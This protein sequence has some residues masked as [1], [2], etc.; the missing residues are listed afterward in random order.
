MPK[1]AK[2]NVDRYKIRGGDLNEF[3]FHQNQAQVKESAEPRQG[4]GTKKAAKPIRGATAKKLAAKK[5]AKK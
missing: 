5:A 3:E 1:D 2:K 4:V